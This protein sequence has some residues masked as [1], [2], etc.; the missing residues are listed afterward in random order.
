VGDGE[1]S[2]IAK[3]CHNVM[4][5]VVIQ[6]LCEITILAEKAGMKRHAF[7]DFLN[8]SVMGSMFTRYKTPALV[9][10][11]FNVTFTPKLLLKDLHL[12][13][14]AGRESGV[15]MPLASTM[16]DQLQQMIGHG[17]TEGDFAMLLLMQAKASGLELKPENKEV[18]DGLSS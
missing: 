2:R 14:D 7:L 13:L 3:I 8:K 12:G 4:L 18:G 15:P 16:R 10:L 9:N 1:L 5:G 6:N 17:L 11:D